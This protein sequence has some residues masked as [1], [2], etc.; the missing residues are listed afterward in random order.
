MVGEL[1]PEQEAAATHRGRHLLLVAGAGTG[2]TRTLVERL[3]RLVEEGEA[4]RRLLAITF[5]NKAAGELRERLQKRLG[6]SVP[7]GTF[8]GTALGWL[9]ASGHWKNRSLY[10]E[11]DQLQLI[12]RLLK[13]LPGGATPQAVKTALQQVRLHPHLPSPDWDRAAQLARELLPRYR[14][15]LDRLHGIDFQGLLEQ[16]CSLVESG[17]LDGRYAEVLVDEFQDTDP[18]QHRILKGLAKGGARIMAVGDDDQ[19]IYGWRGADLMGI[20]RFEQ[21]Y[22]PADVLK[23]TE[24]YRSSEAILMAANQLIDRNIE[25]RGKR[26]RG[27][28]RPGEPIRLLSHGDDRQEAEGVA[29]FAAKFVERE[30]YAPR[31]VAI[32]ARTN[33]QLRPIE[34]ALISRGL[35]Y[36]LLGGTALFDTKEIRDLMAY[37]RLWANPAS[38]PDLLRIANR[39]RRGLGAKAIEKIQAAAGDEALLPWLKD[40]GDSLD[41]RVKKGVHRLLE[42][43]GEPPQTALEGL[44]RVLE[45][46]GYLDFIEAEDAERFEGRQAS[47]EVLIQ[48]A[49]QDLALFLE[50]W[51]LAATGDKGRGQGLRLATCHAAKGL[52]FD[53]V[54]LPGWEEGLFPMIRDGGDPH[55]QLEEERR[56]AYVGLT[57]A[58]HRLVVTWAKRRMLRG[59]W[60]D[61][62][63][64]RFLRDAGLVEAPVRAQP[65]VRRRAPRV[66]PDDVLDQEG[67][68]YAPGFRVDHEVF[69]EGLVLAVRGMGSTASI[70]VR[71]DS[72]EKKT[73]RANF[74]K[75]LGYPD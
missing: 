58:R 66:D 53:A 38:D 67:G 61:S 60:Q 73:I 33:A 70:Q 64:S 34:A 37:L 74:L 36:R 63:P 50:Q 75:P 23:L 4:P 46:M 44:E 62:R 35:D 30:D 68:A 25:R 14:E 22:A 1:N 41:T 29:A 39:P 7:S 27:Q 15:T 26:L 28:G 8:H 48:G 43:L 49:D 71:F 65:S 57:R 13:S 3:A 11:R 21:D 24:N 40:H 42:D 47:M 69:G 52:E 19:A 9:K 10:D 72:G 51:G 56:L 6:Q 18:L 59:Q 55:D 5:T 20:L 2:K 45:T 17:A 54:I 31:E 16:A 12:T 32:L